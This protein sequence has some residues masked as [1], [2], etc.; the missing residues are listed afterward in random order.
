MVSCGMH[1]YALAVFITINAGCAGGYK[2]SYVTGAVVKEFATESYD[3]YSELFNVKLNE[4]DPALNP[5]VTTQTELDECMGPAYAK[6]THEKIE[7]MAKAYHEAAEIQT[8]A[9]LAV[10]GDPEDRRAATA[11][12][13]DSA[14]SLLELFPDGE[15]LVSKLKKLAGRN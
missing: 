4:C 6:E 3:A 10:D 14:M 8:A 2:A 1:R 11:A 13:F 5:T 9:M 7:T 12:V 15:K